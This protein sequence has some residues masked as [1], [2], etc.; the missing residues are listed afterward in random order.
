MVEIDLKEALG[1]RF[2]NQDALG[3]R[4]ADVDIW[5]WTPGSAIDALSAATILDLDPANA[6]ASGGL[7]TSWPDASPAARA[8]VVNSGP[9]LVPNG[10]PNG[11]PTVRFKQSGYLTV[12]GADP[13]GSAHDGEVWALL[14]NDKDWAHNYGPW[15]FGTSIYESFYLYLGGG[16]VREFYDDAGAGTRNGFSPDKTSLLWQIYRVKVSGGVRTFYLNGVEQFSLAMAPA[17]KTQPVIGASLGNPWV[18]SMGRV[19][20]FN[21]ALTDVEAAAVTAELHALYI[22]DAPQVIAV[23]GLTIESS[24]SPVPV[25]LDGIEPGDICIMAAYYYAGNG[26]FVATSV[27]GLGA[28]WNRVKIDDSAP[29]PAVH[30][31]EAVT[32][33]VVTISPHVYR[34][35]YHMWVLRGFDIST[36]TYQASAST[37]VAGP[38][39]SAD[40]GDCVMSIYMDNTGSL[41]ITPTL[42]PSSGWVVDYDTPGSVRSSMYAAHRIADGTANHQ[43][44]GA[45]GTGRVIQ[46]VVSPL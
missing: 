30:W 36:L 2:G 10:T 20:Q 22:T 29:A 15:S 4:V 6:V 7:I 33:G 31:A 24:A 17:W 3:V 40:E 46:F 42:T 26:D 28:T 9:L 12:T 45:P 23:S 8:T 32:D 34:G 27:S 1:V 18:G 25:Y 35:G 44:V 13:G 16:G 38:V 19:L 14:R 5:P 37:T 39:M 21:R 43:M 11:S 41:T